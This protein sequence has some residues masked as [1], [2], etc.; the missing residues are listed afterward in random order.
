MELSPSTWRVLGLSV[1]ATY[2]SLGTFA[3]TAP[4]LAAKCFGIYPDATSPPSTEKVVT[5]DKDSHAKAV[6]TSMLLL[7]ARDLSI[8][9]A[10]AIF[11]YQGNLMATGTLILCGMPLCVVDVAEI[12]RLRG[13]RWGS[14]F[15]A[16]ASIWLLVGYGLVQ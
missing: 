12:W 9:L 11:G 5:T 6:T 13:P 7:G 3:I 4:V 16:G 14:A 1:A 8:G 2:I 15:A 10:L